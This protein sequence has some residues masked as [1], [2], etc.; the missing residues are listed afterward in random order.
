MWPNMTKLDLEVCGCRFSG[1]RRPAGNLR[2]LAAFRLGP[3]LF[4]VRHTARL[5]P[6]IEP[7]PPRGNLFGRHPGCRLGFP[8]FFER[9]L[10]GGS[11]G[12]KLVP[13]YHQYAKQSFHNNTPDKAAAGICLLTMC[14]VLGVPQAVS[15]DCPETVPGLMT[16]SAA[17]L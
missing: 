6:A 13:K 12:T 9:D 8:P 14:R 11:H 17:Y 1:G 5:R 15:T 4:G 7:G 10:D 16:V 2:L 3:G